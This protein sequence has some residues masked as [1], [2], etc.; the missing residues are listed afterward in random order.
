[1]TLAEA[2]KA[3]VAKLRLPWWADP[4]DHLVID[5]IQTPEGPTRGPWVHLYSAT[6]LRLG[7]TNPADILA[8]A[9]TCAD[10]V[11]YVEAG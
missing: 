8:L 3:G 10:Y 4:T 7:Q 5:I 9:D 11:P 1:M 6:N 2:A